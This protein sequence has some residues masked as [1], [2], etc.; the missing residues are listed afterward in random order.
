M[1]VV[2][3]SLICSDTF[4]YVELGV[5]F[6]FYNKLVIVVLCK[7][8]HIPF[9]VIMGETLKFKYCQISQCINIRHYLFQTQK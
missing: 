7:I 5:K 1:S 3:K 6:I 4:V 2:E 9:T 8:N